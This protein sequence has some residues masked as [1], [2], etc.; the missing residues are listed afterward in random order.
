MAGRFLLNSRFIS[1]SGEPLHLRLP[2]EP[3]HLPLGVVAV[4]LLRRPDRQLQVNFSAQMLR[5]LLVAEAWNFNWSP[6]ST[7]S[8]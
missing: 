2:P 4:R 7:V 5:R 3:C 1:E 8:E 6:F